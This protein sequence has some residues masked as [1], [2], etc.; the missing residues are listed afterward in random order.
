MAE[1]TRVKTNLLGLVKPKVSEAVRVSDFNSNSDILDTEFGLERNFSTISIT[2]SEGAKSVSISPR[3]NED[4]KKADSEWELSKMGDT[5]S[6]SINKGLSATVDGRSVTVGHERGVT[7][8]NIGSTQKGVQI[9]Y[10]SYGHI[11]QSG[12][13]AMYPPL[14]A[15]T[16]KQVWSS[17][18]GGSKNG[19]WRNIS[20]GKGIALS[21]SDDYVIGH[22]KTYGKAEVGGVSSIPRIEV[23]LY[24]HVVSVKGNT[25]YPPTTKGKEDQVYTSVGE[26]EGNGTWTTIEANSGIGLTKQ[27]ATSSVDKKFIIGHTN[28]VDA[29]S[30]VG[31]QTA[32]PVISYDAQ[33]HITKTETKVMYP[34]ITGAKSGMFWRSEGEDTRGSWANIGVGAGLKANWSFTGEGDA[35]T[36]TYTVLHSNSVT[37]KTNVGSQTAVPVISYD[38]EGHIAAT[39][40]KVMYPPVTGADAGKIWASNGADAVGKWATLSATDGIKVDQSNPFV[41][42]TLKHTNSVT[43]GSKGSASEIP[44]VSWDAQGHVTGVSGTAVYPP[45]SKGTANQVWVSVGTG[46][47]NGKWV[48]LSD[49]TG[50]SITKGTS[51]F[52]INHSNSVTTG[53]KGSATEIPK[54]TW[55]GQGHLTA[56]TSA[57]VYPPTSA[58]TSGQLWASKGAEEGKWVNPADITVGK[59]TNAEKLDSGTV[60]GEIKPVFFKNGVPVAI[61]HTIEK[62]VPSDAVFTDTTYTARAGGGLILN[63]TEFFVN[64][65]GSKTRS[66][67]EF[68]SSEYLHSLLMSSDKPYIVS[69][70]K[71]TIDDRL[72]NL[73][74][75]VGT[76]SS[77]SLEDKSLTQR[78]AALESEVDGINGIISTAQGKIALDADSTSTALATHKVVSSV[79]SAL[80]TSIAGVKKTADWA[81]T[82]IAIGKNK[83]ALDSSTDLANCKIVKSAINTEAKARA[84][85]DDAL[86]RRI[87]TNATNIATNKT[88]IT[89]L[90]TRVDNAETRNTE[91]DN[92]I[93]DINK[94]ISS[95]N[96]SLSGKQGTLMTSSVTL[97][98]AGWSGGK[99]SATV[100]G[101]TDTGTVW[102]CPNSSSARIWINAGVYTTAQSAN[103]LTFV[104]S[105]VP[106]ADITVN[107]VFM[108]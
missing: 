58:G 85:A 52:T 43:A 6:V 84:D 7:A 8:K 65:A 5:L 18:G 22:E 68:V 17:D 59:A 86:S 101:L 76:S 9:G 57:T 54:I 14:E 4:M 64:S 82:A 36:G 19:K 23:D 91:Q 21:K 93:S 89:D 30:G 75:K 20:A 32:V 79:K 83:T 28:S 106:T 50:I 98:T 45:T 25:V 90:T 2:P 1:D 103:A 38:T 31:S 92:A 46:S 71:S 94:Q 99:Q 47:G 81:S 12:E 67:S 37:A 88:N 10:D 29:K 34:P 70:T 51:E 40:T 42:W 78:V 73:E 13:F 15:G 72:T 27:S 48:A 56:I 74:S 60:G 49:G 26:K 108:V 55:D 24:G 11:Y 66:T 80:E 53:S 35:R 107:V 39:E 77:P 62:N 69:E 63:G 104:C 100:K 33:G 3:S 41:G 95:I 44:V 102:V 97:T 105:T 16:N 87:T 61:T 96:T